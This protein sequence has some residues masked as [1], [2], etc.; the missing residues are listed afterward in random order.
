VNFRRGRLMASAPGRWSIMSFIFDLV[1]HPTFPIAFLADARAKAE[2][3]CVG[4]LFS[5]TRNS[6]RTSSL[7]E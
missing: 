1:F 7:F 2:S 5:E 4:Q 3:Q 6:V